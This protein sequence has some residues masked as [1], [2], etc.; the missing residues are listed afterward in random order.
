M[1][2]ESR[3]GE[4]LENKLDEGMCFPSLPSVLLLSCT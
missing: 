2:S 3:S 4:E 1:L